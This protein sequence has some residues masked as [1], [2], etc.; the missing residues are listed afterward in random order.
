MNSFKY[1]G[2]MFTPYGNIT[3]KDNDTRFQRL[4]W[5]LD[6]LRP[7]LNTESGY[8]YYEFYEVAGEN[9]ADIYYVEEK[10]MYYVPTGG[11]ICRI[12]EKEMKKYI[13]KLSLTI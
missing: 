4:M 6:T 10:K 9:S 11:G 7:L 2:Y 1:L 12:D 13:K 3:G 5:R 8:D